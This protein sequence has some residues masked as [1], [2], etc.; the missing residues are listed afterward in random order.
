MTSRYSC[1][2]AGWGVSGLVAVIASALTVAAV[3]NGFQLFPALDQG[4]L[5]TQYACAYRIANEAH[6]GLMLTGVVTRDPA[7][8]PV[9]VDW[10]G[11][12]A[13]AFSPHGT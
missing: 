2:S 13:G 8:K 11:S 3:L 12:A 9:Y 1:P 10:E 7:A 6:T 4:Y 5:S